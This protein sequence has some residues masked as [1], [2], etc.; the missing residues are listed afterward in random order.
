MKISPEKILISQEYPHRLSYFTDDEINLSYPFHYHHEVW[1]LTL[2]LGMQGTRLVGDQ[3]DPFDVED[4]VLLGPDLPHSW[5]GHKKTEAQQKV[6]VWQF[7]KNFPGVPPVQNLDLISIGNMLEDASLGIEIIGRSRKKIAKILKN[8]ISQPGHI[9]YLALL[10]VLN[11]ITETIEKR[12]ICS[13]NY[14]YIPRQEES[15]RFEEVHAFIKDH[16]REKIKLETVAAKANLSPTA[17]SH[18]FKKHSLKSFTDFVNELRLVHVASQLTTSN[19]P[20][21]EIAFDSG[22]QNLSIFNRLFKRKYGISPM[23]YR[24]KRDFAYQI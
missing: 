15:K 10:S 16:Y 18:Y 13:S 14:H 1:E 9:K 19:R 3:F 5:Y 7:G 6:I 12:T 22:F 24:K 11:I 23:K 8:I 2:T 17:F 21:A 20:V 4:L